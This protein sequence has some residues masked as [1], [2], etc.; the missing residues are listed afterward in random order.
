MTSRDCPQCGAPN[1]ADGNFCSRCGAPLTSQQPQLPSTSEA[2]VQERK[3]VS[4]LFADIVESTAIVED[5]DPEDALDQLNPAIKAMRASV[6]RFGGTLCREQGDGVMAFFG[7]PRADDHH[8]VNACLAGLEIVRAVDHLTHREMKARVGIHSG[9]VVVRLIEGEFG[10]SYD[11]SGAS[12]YLANRLESLAR[13][14]SVM[15][16]AATLTLAAPYFDF[17]SEPPVVPKGFTQP[18]PV[19]SI[20]GQRSISRW[21]ARRGKGFS[22]FVGRKAELQCLQAISRGVEQGVGKIALLSGN[23]GTGKSRLAHEFIAGLAIDGWSIIEAEAQPAGQATPYGVLKRMGL[24]W[25]GC[26]ELDSATVIGAELEQRLKQT[27][28]CPSWTAAALRSILDLPVFEAAWADAEP[29]FR[30]RHVINAVKFVIGSSAKSFPLVS[31]VEDFHWIDAESAHVIEQ[32]EEDLPGLHLLILGTTRAV[33]PPPTIGRQQTRIDLNALDETSGAELLDALL[34]TEAGLSELKKRLLGH[35]GGVPIFMEEVVRRLTDT[36]A[37]VGERGAYTL[38]IAPEDIGIPLSVQNIIAT[39]VDAL[40]AAAKRVLQ[41]AA[42]LTKPITASLLMAMSELSDEELAVTIKL[43]EEAGFLTAVRVAPDVEFAF[44]H[45]LM[46]EVVYSALMREQRRALHGKALA[47]CLQVLPDR[48]GEFAGPLSHHAYESQNW[49]MVLRFSREAAVRALERSAF[50]EAAV[51]FQRAIESINRQS[52][53]RTLNEIAIDVRLQSRLAFSATSQLAVWIEYAKEAE[54]MAAAIGDDRRELTAI[55]NRALAINFAGSPAESLKLTEPALQRAIKNGFEDLELSAWYTIAQAHYAAGEFR[56]A[57]D[58]LTG[59]VERLRGG[60]LL[61]RFGTAGT[62]SVL[63]LTMTAIATAS[64]GEFD[65]SRPALDEAAEIAGQTGRPYDSVSCYYG[66]GLLFMYS[67]HPAKAIGEFRKGLD[68]CREF[69]INLFIPLIVGQLGAALAAVG[70]HEQAIRLLD[71][72]VKESTVLGHNAATAFANYALAS[73]YREAG[74]LS[75]AIEL[76]ETWLAV[77]V[78]YGLRAV[79]MRFLHLLGILRSDQGDTVAAELLLSRATE[80]AKALEAGPTIAQ[81]QLSLAQLWS[82]ASDYSRAVQAAES[83]T[84]LYRQLG[85]EALAEKAHQ[86]QVAALKA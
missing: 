32:L 58:L 34:G 67:G 62:T 24:S 55:I 64:M 59:Q 83:A 22:P 2:E 66:R 5:L 70:S 51:Q 71:R 61:K 12:V 81:V 56:K 30:R 20:S 60:S 35:T 3:L 37:L 36:G 9:E 72:V 31:L 63:F 8:A 74:K 15:V 29:G 28:A 16:S 38:T 17:I 42:V 75:E 68:V 78:R 48:V 82:K 46:R 11:A 4:I 6:K 13:A 25:L 50:R 27:S 44:A 14:G 23:A 21:M 73:A 10:T 41:S 86:V 33:S 45:E 69:S 76:A 39:R 49:G 18:I 85:C 7:A 65:R 57:T 47:A 1:S 26:S 53:S 40:P 79:E 54:E 52:A 84:L 80:L 43:I 77:A 19:F